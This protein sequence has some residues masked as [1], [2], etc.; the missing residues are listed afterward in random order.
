MIPAVA[1]PMVALGTEKVGVF[2][3]L[4]ASARNSIRFDSVITKFFF[5]VTSS[6]CN[7]SPRRMLRPP[8]P[9]V[10]LVGIANALGLNQRLGLGFGTDGS[11][12]TLG[13]WLPMPVFALS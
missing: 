2:V 9:Y 3:M 6:S 5:S 7:P 1:P 12:T 4:N 13:R 8:L 11:P 10:Y